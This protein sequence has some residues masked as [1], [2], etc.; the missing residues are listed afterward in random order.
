MLDV[1]VERGPVTHV[2]LGGDLDPS[3]APRL[4]ATIAELVADDRV[5]RVVLDLGG[6]A[7][8][9]SSGLRV[10]VTA[11]EALAGRGAALALRNPTGNTR[12][13][14]DITGLGE[15]ISVE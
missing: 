5:E 14:L 8:V 11:R 4:E 7:F 6:L 12:R 3:T 2:R 1:E 13:L 15:I 9:D 10:F